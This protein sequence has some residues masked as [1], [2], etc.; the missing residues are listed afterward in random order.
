[1]EWRV[2]VWGITA[3]I[4]ILNGRECSV[5]GLDKYIPG[6]DPTLCPKDVGT[7]KSKIPNGPHPAKIYF[8]E[9]PIQKN[10]AT[11]DCWSRMEMERKNNIKKFLASVGVH[12]HSNRICRP[13]SLSRGIWLLQ[14]ILQRCPSCCAR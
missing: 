4:Q 2:H 7:R 12:T 5:K 3:I 14:F 11:I 8:Y 6:Q 13:I 1:M 9:K 10:F